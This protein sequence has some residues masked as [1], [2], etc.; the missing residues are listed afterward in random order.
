MKRVLHLIETYFRHL[1]REIT[2]TLCQ[3][4]FHQSA[5]RVPKWACDEVGFQAHTFSPRRR[6]RSRRRSWSRRRRSKEPGYDVERFKSLAT[7]L[8]CS[9]SIIGINIIV[10]II[11]VLI[12][13]ISIMISIT[14][15]MIN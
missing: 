13:I 10:S 1:G 14:I 8:Q 3:I 9:L 7:T 12:I 11:N 6:S 15:I 4:N 5:G 2:D